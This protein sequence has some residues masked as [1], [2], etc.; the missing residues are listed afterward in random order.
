MMTI[1]ERE[2]LAMSLVPVACGLVE[3]VRNRDIGRTHAILGDHSDHL[4]ALAVVLASLVPE[5]ER[6][7]ALD[8]DEVAVQRRLWGDKSVR[9]NHAEQVEALRRWQALGEPLNE[10]ERRTGLNYARLRRSAA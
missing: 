8:V 6:L 4:S 2:T 7:A 1:E 9:L 5:E 10:F 3:A